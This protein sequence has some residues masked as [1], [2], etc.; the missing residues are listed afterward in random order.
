MKDLTGQVFGR[1]TVIAFHSVGDKAYLWKCLCVCGKERLVRRGNLMCG[2]TKVC[3]CHRTK[4]NVGQTYNRLTVVEDLGYK[5][6]HGKS[7]HWAKCVCSC[8]NTIEVRV[9]SIRSNHA[10]SCGC[11]AKEQISSHGY[12]N[13]TTYKA[14]Q[15]LIQ[16]C[17]NPK[18]KSYKRYGGRGIRVCDRW[19]EC[20]E[21]FLEDMGDRPEGGFS[22]DRINND[23]NY[24]PS[25]CRWATQIEQAR[26]TSRYIRD[27]FSYLSGTISSSKL[28]KIRK[29]ANSICL[30]CSFKAQS[31]AKYCEVC[32]LRRRLRYWRL[33]WILYHTDYADMLL[34]TS[35]DSR[36]QNA[37]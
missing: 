11:Y 7:V 4:F 28:S 33:R 22:L 35:M 13:D 26:N 37:R 32:I 15:G 1:Y 19:L 31:N 24:E 6:T 8:G 18:D 5:L 3:T 12:T 27:E 36:R 17:T 16:R 9:A 34:G 14:W 30:E 2:K 25:N 20:F 23:G 29:V 21:N 10:T